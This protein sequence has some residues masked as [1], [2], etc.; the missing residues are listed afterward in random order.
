MSGPEHNPTDDARDDVTEEDWDAQI[1]TTPPRRRETVF[2]AYKNGEPFELKGR[3]LTEDEINNY[4]RSRYWWA[5]ALLS[6]V[7]GGLG[8]LT[9]Q[10]IFRN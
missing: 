5:W 8:T 2:I 3:W 7:I 6:G 1:K 9:G 4:G 10:W